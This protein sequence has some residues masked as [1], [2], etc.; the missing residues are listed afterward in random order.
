ME[1]RFPH[2]F[3]QPRHEAVR[4]AKRASVHAADLVLCI[5][6]TTQE[7]VC[8]FL[9]IPAAKTRTITLASSPIFRPLPP[10]ELAAPTSLPPE[11]FFLYLGDRSPY[12]NFELLARAFAAWPH[13]HEAAL[14]AIGPKFVAAE[15]SLLHDL[16]LAERVYSYQNIDDEALCRFYNQAQ[17]FV[18]PSLYEGFGIPLLE[19]MACG[20]SL[21]ASDIPTTRAVAGDIPFYFEP[22]DVAGLQAALSAAL[23]STGRAERSR[24]GIE[25]AGAFSWDATAG[26]VLAIYRELEAWA[27]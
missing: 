6:R 10:A 13:R 14:V 22:T 3:D 18:Y 25:R 7:D 8:N 21:V 23:T 12:K 2:F 17:A 20:C 4:R 5:S 26:Q 16:G 15:Q 1:E 27:S 9:Q 11:P 19:A 24:A